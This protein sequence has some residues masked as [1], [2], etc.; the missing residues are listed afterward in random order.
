MDKKVVLAGFSVVVTLIM[1]TGVYASDMLSSTPLYMVRMEQQSNDMNFLPT[2]INE[3]TYSAETGY[4]ITYNAGFCGA[5]P[6]GPA[7]TCEQN[8]CQW[9]VDTCPYTC[10]S[11]CPATCFETCPNT[12]WGATCE[13]STCGN[14]P[15]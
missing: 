14:P 11:T 2:E 8:P 9:T 12:C 6:L 7:P 13:G 4:T 10:L 1:V 5:S 3:F 15:C